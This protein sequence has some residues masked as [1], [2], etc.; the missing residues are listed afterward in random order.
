MREKTQKSPKRLK[1]KKKGLTH[2]WIQ[3]S[4]QQQHCLEDNESWFQSSVEHYK[5]ESKIRIFR[6]TIHHE[7][8]Q[9]QYIFWQ[10]SGRLLRRGIW[11][12][13]SLLLRTWE[14]LPQNKEGSKEGKMGTQLQQTLQLA[15]STP[16]PTRFVCARCY[17][18]WKVKNC[19]SLALP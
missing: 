13:A 2:Q 9:S 16:V 10:V 12:A 19:T 7:Q 17:R 18:A 4:S 1:K 3:N 15:R 8:G 11:Q 6:Q 5:I 14:V